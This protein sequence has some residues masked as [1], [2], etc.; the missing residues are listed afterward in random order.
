MTFAFAGGVTMT[1]KPGRD[2]TKF[3]GSRRLDPDLA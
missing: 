3:I 2:S 1:F